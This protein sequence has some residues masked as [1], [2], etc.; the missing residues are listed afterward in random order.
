MILK[1]TISPPLPR[2]MLCLNIYARRRQSFTEQIQDM[3]YLPPRFV[4]STLLTEEG[5]LE[6]AGPYKSERCLSC[7]RYQLL[8]MIQTAKKSFPVYQDLQKAHSLLF[9]KVV[10]VEEA[11]THFPVTRDLLDYCGHCTKTLDDRVWPFLIFFCPT[12]SLTAGIVSF[13]ILP[14][15]C[16]ASLQ[17]TNPI[18]VKLGTPPHY[19]DA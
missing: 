11:V 14:I 2:A 16:K 18:F 15:I 6:R 7:S 9:A 19:L 4:W 3:Y 1:C 13:H 17:F 10:A 8:D 12:L 5:I